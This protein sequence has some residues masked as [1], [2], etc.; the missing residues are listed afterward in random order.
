MIG[1]IAAPSNLGLRPP[2]PGAVPG[3]AKAP[4]ALREAGLYANLKDARDY[5]VVLPG[6]YRDDW[7]PGADRLRNQDAI[8]D[9]S[10]RLAAR[11]TRVL[12]DGNFPLVLGGDC[13]ILVG[14][15]LALRGRYG[16]VHVDGHTDF[17]N[18]TNSAQCASLAGEDLAA[19]VG[20]HWDAIADLDGLRP[21]FDPA[22]TVHIGCRDDD[23]GLAEASAVLRAVIPAKQ[24]AVAI[25][26]IG[27]YW[28]HVDVDVLDP[29]VL[30]AVD[31]PDP[32]GLTAAELTGL[33]RSLRPG[34]VGIQ[35]TV[36]D[37]DL[38]PDGR[39]ADLLATLIAEVLG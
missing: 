24:H 14:A 9:H 10:R 23:E 19:A 13:G 3:C 18:P 22:R 15:G 35:F 39:Y 5:G 31:S 17:R 27:G 21:Y 7:V 8:I 28:L 33:L 20:R 30:P 32:G 1:I 11:I 34:A 16:L 29:S 6:R 36:F 2:E 25:P 37:P 4:E 26:D 12:D 38:D